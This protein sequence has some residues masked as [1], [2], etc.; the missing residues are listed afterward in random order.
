MY[1]IKE[2]ADKMNM[3][4][5][6]LRYYANQGLFPAIERDHNN[7]RWFNENGLD[8]IKLVKCLRETGMPIAEVKKFVRLHAAG[9][10][11]WE[12]RLRILE[13][14]RYKA[15]NDL[16]AMKERIALLEKK[17]DFYRKKLQTSRETKLDSCACGI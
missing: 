4:V 12:E 15:Q 14:Q 10:A 17:T 7:I 5:H 11:T 9:D 6:T 1:T 16:E 13:E 3:S 8:S 2:A